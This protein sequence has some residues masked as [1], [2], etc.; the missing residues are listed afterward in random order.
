M[1]PQKKSAGFGFE[2]TKTFDTQNQVT[3]F[4]RLRVIQIVL[5]KKEMDIDTSITPIQ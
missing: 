5:I 4:Q 1:A 2:R 3:S